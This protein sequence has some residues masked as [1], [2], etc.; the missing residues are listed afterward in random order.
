MA[1]Q[2]IVAVREANIRDAK[3]KDNAGRSAKSAALNIAEAAGRESAGD[4]KRVFGIARGE[5]TEALAAV[6]IAAAA[7]D[8]PQ[9]LAARCI[10]I[11]ARLVALL[12]GLIR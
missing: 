6:E 7:G 11:G 2:F 5:V 4:K 10:A 8:A 3:L 1:L 9:E 12:R